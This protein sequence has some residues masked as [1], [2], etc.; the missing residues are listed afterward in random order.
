MEEFDNVQ[1][2]YNRGQK[3]RNKSKNSVNTMMVVL[4]GRI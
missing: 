3:R 4:S 2:K 1:E